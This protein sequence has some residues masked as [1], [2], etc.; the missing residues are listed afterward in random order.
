MFIDCKL[1]LKSYIP[2]KL[3]K[4]MWF[5][6]V[7]TEVIYGDKTEYLCV[8]ELALVPRDMETYLTFNGYPVK[9]YLVY[10]MINPDDTEVI[11]ATPDQIGWWDEGEHVDELRDITVKD[12]NNILEW[13]NSM[14][15]IEVLDDEEDEEDGTPIPL[16]YDNKVT[17]RD[18]HTIDSDDWIDD[19]DDDDDY[20][21][22]GDDDVWDAEDHNT[23]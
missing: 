13:D 23:E 20:L 1:V 12:I 2:E 8:H 15:Q 5:V 19:D 10:P 17:L 11:A 3:E 6:R 9:P 7:K 16:L 18:V 4:G 14:V 21:D 22:D